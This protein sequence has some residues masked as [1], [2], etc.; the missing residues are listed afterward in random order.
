MFR[1]I[2][3]WTH[4]CCG[5]AAGL[6]IFTMSLTGVLLTY[7]RQIKE[8]MARQHY[9]PVAA[10]QERLPLERLLELQQLADPSLQASALV[11]TNDP[12]APV[13]FR[14][15]RRVGPNLNPYT[16]EQFP[17]AAPRMDATFAWLTGFH[18][19]FNVEGEQ[20]ALARQITGV[21]NV[22]FLFL[23][24]SGLYLWLPALYKWAVFKVRL[25]FKPAYPDSKAR[26]FHW[27]H[28]FGFWS[29]VPL[30]AVVYTG[31][32]ISY[33]WAANL[34]YVALGVEIPAP[35]AAPAAPATAASARQ[36][37][38]TP[39]PA[40]NQPTALQQSDT[41]QGSAVEP[42]Y[43]VLAFK[44]LDTLVAAAL[45][46]DSAEWKRLTLTLPKAG[47]TSLQVEIDNGNGAQAQRRHTL[48]LDR[49]SGAVQEQRGFGDL[50]DAQ[51]LRGI[52]R[53][54]HTGEVLGFWGQTVAGLVSLFALFLVWTGFA[55]SWRRLIV[56][57][58][59]KKQGQ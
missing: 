2:I 57:L 23:I 18:R 42:R 40:V 52:A 29:A 4:L 54:L 33:P 25:W 5:I 30:F 43:D 9:V 55:L 31:A 45:A 36:A 56:P 17:V 3:F 58:L 44:S 27:H 7:E 46:H 28:I 49:V 12:G 32:V 37:A 51:R 13:S 21:S 14:A 15:G 11:V 19:W 59:R 6:V 47:D 10:Q 53:F 39:A 26:D 1:R 35:P 8:Y 16:G 24:L 50:P 38:A 41:Q 22:I 34:M 48:V 20:R